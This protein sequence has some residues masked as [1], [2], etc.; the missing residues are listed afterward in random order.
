MD[1]LEAEKHIK[2]ESKVHEKN[3][4]KEKRKRIDWQID[5][6][7]RDVD[8]SA[9]RPER[10]RRDRKIKELNSEVQQLINETSA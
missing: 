6:C 1:A 10:Q 7:G 3:G 2:E 5:K 4:R 9:N 8:D